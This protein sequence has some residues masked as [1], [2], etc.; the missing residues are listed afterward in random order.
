MHYIK[1][2]THART[3]A[4]ILP[5]IS[6]ISSQIIHRNPSG[7][8]PTSLRLKRTSFESDCDLFLSC[9]PHSA[10]GRVHEHVETATKSLAEDEVNC[11]PSQLSLQNDCAGLLSRAD[12]L[13]EAEAVERIQIVIDA[14]VERAGT[15]FRSPR[16]LMV[17]SVDWTRTIEDP[18]KDRERQSPKAHAA[19][20]VGG[21]AMEQFIES[22]IHRRCGQ[23]TVVAA[24]RAGEVEDMVGW[25]RISFDSDSSTK[26]VDSPVQASWCYYYLWMP[27]NLCKR[28]RRR[29]QQE[30]GHCKW[31]EPRLE[32]E[33]SGPM[34]AEPRLDRAES[35][36]PV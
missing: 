4:H 15:R 2:C 6:H 14:Q 27:A 31:A 18:R 35:S 28:L 25:R 29:Q 20:S 21:G 16:S 10:P 30:Q 17:H 22:P 32:R 34:R 23:Q 8:S 26:S 5:D 24:S 12:T 19:Q 9:E 13:S 11:D 3:H 36:R 33:C 1:S 7:L